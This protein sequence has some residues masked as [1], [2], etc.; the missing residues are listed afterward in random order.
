MDNSLNSPAASVSQTDLSSSG[1]S[2][3]PPSA[4]GQGASGAKTG[5]AGGGTT[6]SAPHQM[7][8]DYWKKDLFLKRLSIA[9]TIVGFLFLFGSIQ[10]TSK[11]LRNNIQQSMDRTVLEMDKVFVDRPELSAYVFGSAPIGTNDP[12]YARAE[13]AATMVLDVFVAAARQN[14]QYKGLWENPEGW[15]NWIEDSLRHSSFLREQ[16]RSNTNWYPSLTY[17]LDKVD[18]EL[19]NKKDH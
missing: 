7:Q 4:E 5:G 2:M 13:I 1:S 12:N 8:Q 15:D 14:D 6:S 19:A 3:G 9:V 10:I 11:N 18:K 16:L 17:Y